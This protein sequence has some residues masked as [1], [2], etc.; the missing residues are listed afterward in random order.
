MGKRHPLG[1]RVGVL[2]L[3][4]GV[5]AAGAAFLSS[6]GD[7]AGPPVD[8]ACRHLT[9]LLSERLGVVAA[10]VTA[11][12]FLTMAGIARLDRERSTLSGRRSR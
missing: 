9:V 4:V 11:V 6:V 10:V 5:L 3:V 2:A 1:V 7:C 8:A 12:F